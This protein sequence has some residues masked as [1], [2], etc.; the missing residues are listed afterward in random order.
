MTA[1]RDPTTDPRPGDVVRGK[2]GPERKV[3][4]VTPDVGV[5]YRYGEDPVTIIYDTPTK[6]QLTC[7]LR[8]WR[9]WAKGA[10]VVRKGPEHELRDNTR[11]LSLPRSITQQM[12]WFD[13]RYVESLQALT[14]EER[15]GISCALTED[16]VLAF[17]ELGIVHAIK[18]HQGKY[19][20]FAILKHQLSRRNALRL[21]YGAKHKE[22]CDMGV[23]CLCGADDNTEVV[24]RPDEHDPDAASIT[25]DGFSR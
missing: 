11:P 21:P 18:C 24:A 23:D 20:L 12:R 25:T 15:R 7:G 13:N 16:M 5:S 10:L 8:A 22:G 2:T 6:T 4:Y 3:L 14:E 9:R 19:G 17:L 1:V